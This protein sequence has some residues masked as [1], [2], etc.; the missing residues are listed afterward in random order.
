[1]SSSLLSRYGPWALVTGAS[2]GFGAEF[3]VQLAEE[4]FNLVMTAR[5]Y[6]RLEQLAE[7]LETSF[8]IQTRVIPADLS[9]LEFL[10]LLLEKTVDLKI[11]LLVSSAGFASARNFMDSD[12]KCELDM[13]H[14]NC[15]AQMALAHSFGRMMCERQ[16]G[17]IIFISSIAGISYSPPWSSYSASK[18]YILALAESLWLDLK[19]FGVDVE[20]LCPGRADTE[21]LS[22]AEINMKKATWGARI[23]LTGV[24]SSQ[25]VHEGLRGLGRK[26]VVIPG[27]FNRAAAWGNSLLPRGLLMRITASIM[28][29]VQPDQKGQ[30]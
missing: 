29:S 17:G 3:C 15:R 26:R 8:C 24:P 7:G 6:E 25:V 18:A 23:F 13:L 27:L 10:P 30:R 16:K 28:K 2:S 20:A 5:R 11:G 19:P 22:V 12:L 21:F 14:V 9:N 1:M 4:G